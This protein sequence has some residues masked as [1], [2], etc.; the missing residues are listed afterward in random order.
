MRCSIGFVL[1]G[2]A[3]AFAQ[4]PA[5]FI[6]NAGQADPNIRYMVQTPGLSAGFMLGEALFQLDRLTVQ[7]RF[8]GASPQPTLEGEDRLDAAANFLIGNREQD[9]KTNLPV[10]RKI[11]YRNLYPGIDMTYGGAGLSIKSEFLVA[12][13]ADP[14]QIRLDYSDGRLSIAPNGDLLIR[15]GNAEAR[16]EAPVIYQNTAPGVYQ[17]AASGGLVEISGRYALIDSHTVGFEIDAYDR[18]LPLIIDPVLTYA[19][20]LGGSGMG[21]ITGIAV[22]SSGDLYATGWTESLNYQIAAPIQASNAGGVDAVVL[23]LDPAGNA[24]LYATYIGG[25]SDD[26][27]AAIAVDSSGEAYVT[28]STASSNFPLASPLKSTLGGGRDAFV[29]KLNSPR[30]PAGL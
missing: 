27:G 22:D 6:P 8:K 15:N 5:F 3:P 17:D 25:S 16:E 19:T 4:L 11:L 23:K 14:N 24:L 26:R 2:A 1:L 29:L 28:G 10:Y 30:Q 13:G 9:W 12:P 18:S 7:V 21:A 20:Y